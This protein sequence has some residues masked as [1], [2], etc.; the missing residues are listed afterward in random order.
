MQT[1]Y[2]AAIPHS[3]LHQVEFLRANP[4]LPFDTLVGT[5][6]Q[7]EKPPPSSQASPIHGVAPKRLYAAVPHR[8]FPLR[9]VRGDLAMLVA[10]DAMARLVDHRLP[11]VLFRGSRPEGQTKPNSCSEG[12]GTVDAVAKPSGETAVPLDDD[13]LGQLGDFVGFARKSIP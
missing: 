10:N 2:F 12:D 4:A 7:D 9:T 6:E 11:T 8:L 5:I 13:G 3:L 1:A